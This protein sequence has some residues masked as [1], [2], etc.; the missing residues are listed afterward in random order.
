M[1]IRFGNE[2]LGRCTLNHHEPG[3]VI[4]SLEAANIIANSFCSFKLIRYRFCVGALDPLNVFA[5]EYGWHGLD[6]SQ[7]IGNGLDI[8]IPVQDP[9]LCC[10]PA[11]VGHFC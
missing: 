3:A 2:F 5:V 8:F 10:Q 9:A 11:K 1:H 6:A 7:E 4:G